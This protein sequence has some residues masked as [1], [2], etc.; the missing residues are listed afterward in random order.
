MMPSYYRQVSELVDLISLEKPIDF[1]AY[2]FDSAKETA[3][4]GAYG[5]YKDIINNV[6]LNEDEK[7][8]SLVSVLSY[9][10]LENT[11]LHLEIMRKNG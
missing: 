10:I 5:Q 9:L 6:D 1:E 8:Q 3:I 4:I 11:I 2:N 7:E